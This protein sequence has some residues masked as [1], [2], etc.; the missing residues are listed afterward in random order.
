GS[1]NSASQSPFSNPNTAEAFARSFVSN[2]V[3]SGEFGAQGAEDFDD[4]IQSLIQAQ[5]MGKGRHDTK[6]KAKAMQVALASSIAELVIA[7]SSGGDVQ[8]KTNVISNALRNALM[9]TTGSPNEE[10]V[11]EVQ[12]LIQMLSQEQINEV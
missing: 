8:R 7:E 4:I 6:A 11:H 9:S 5:S 3:S 2:I 12:D 10:F 1:G